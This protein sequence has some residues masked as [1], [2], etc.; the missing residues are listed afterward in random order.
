MYPA[1]FDYHRPETLQE[2]IRI[3]HDSGGEATVLAGGQSLIP[4]M[5]MRMGEF[6]R[7]VDIGRLKDLSSSLE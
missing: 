6:P 5:K 3:L 2:A 1:P 4:M 7:I